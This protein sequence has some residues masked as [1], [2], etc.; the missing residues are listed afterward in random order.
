MQVADRRM[1][2]SVGSMIV[3]SGRSSIRTS[4]GACR[5][6]PRMGVLLRSG[7]LLEEERLERVERDE[8]GAIIQV[9]VAGARHDHQCAPSFRLVVDG[10]AEVPGVAV[11]VANGR[12]SHLPGELERVAVVGL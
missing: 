2:A 7:D 3:G 5:T 1:M 4:P 9:D 8:I 12:A 10:L 6:A 11:P